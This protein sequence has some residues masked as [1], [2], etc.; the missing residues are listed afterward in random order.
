M[1]LDANTRKIEK[2]GIIEEIKYHIEDAGDVITQL[3]AGQYADPIA[4]FVRE[5]GTNAY[6]AHQEIK[7]E[8][9]PFLVELP[10][11]TDNTWR[12]RDYGPGLSIEQIKQLYTAVGGST[13]RDSN[14][15]GGMFGLGSK[16]PLAYTDSFSVN[17]YYNGTRY[18]Y[19]VYRDEMDFPHFDL[20]DQVDTD[21][22]NG[23]EIRVPIKARDFITLQ[24][25]VNE[26]YRHFKT[27]PTIY[28][29]NGQSYQLLPPQEKERINNFAIM[30]GG[31]RIKMGNIV[32]PVDTTGEFST[33]RNYNI[34]VELP[35]GS[36]D[37]ATSRE[38]LKYTL[39]TRTAI[40]LAFDFAKRTFVKSLE[41]KVNACKDLWSASIKAH[42]V[43]RNYAFITYKD[44]KY[45][46]LDIL[47]SNI[48][49]S[50]AD[51]KEI[52]GGGLR[53]RRVGR[54]TYISLYE[55][56]SIFLVDSEKDYRAKAK[57]YMG[58]VGSTV[59]LFVKPDKIEDL[60]TL[61][62]VDDSS[63]HK[64]S[65]LKY[66]RPKY[67][68]TKNSGY[69]ILR[70]KGNLGK[71]SSWELLESDK[72]ELDKEH[73][74]VRVNNVDSLFRGQVIS[75]RELD[76]I[77]HYLGTEIYGIRM[78]GKIPKKWKCIEDLINQDF[79]SKLIDDYHNELSLRRININGLALYNIGKIIDPPSDIKEFYLKYKEIQ[80]RNYSNFFPDER[81]KLIQRLGG[82][83]VENFQTDAEK[84]CWQIKQKYPLLFSLNL[85]S[86]PQEVFNE[87][88]EFYLKRK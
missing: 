12:I 75:H 3:V 88:N 59:A 74:Y 78:T 60:K 37:V 14:K 36:V 84:L 42:E 1:K 46:G 76:I 47:A 52:R 4:A 18:S 25:R 71:S 44:L 20:V 38:Q 29:K 61:L 53:D 81:L 35:I 50:N 21:E 70:F 67:T 16:S 23:L 6:E 63:I 15:M 45:K 79:V 27:Y 31:P 58:T 2:F 48:T 66:E 83:P 68:R 43:V 22:P 19:L 10:D 57:A 62:Q 33:L 17:S 54:Q 80:Q 55:K 87:L 5:L 24:I 49:I 85:Y 65:E 26:I 30:D 69:K 77:K 7:C 9:K 73:Y 28:K 40:K 64:I 86:Q 72:I 56:P 41:E 11:A 34:M 32:Y 82:K 39:K 51:L 13:K 8:D